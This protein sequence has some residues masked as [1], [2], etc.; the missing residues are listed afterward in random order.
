M[1][2]REKFG[3]LVLLDE[4]EAG[5]LGREYRA[6]R[7]GPAGLDRFV[8][9]L[10]FGPEVSSNAEA[11][12]RL[13]EEAR[14]AARLQSP[15]LVRV[16]G[17]GRVEQSFYVSTE[18][19]EGR[20][21]A[22]TLE[23]CRGDA[24][25]FAAEHALMIASRAAS[26]LEFLHGKKDDAGAA[27]V[28]GLIAPSRLVVAF[29][30]EVKLKGLGLWPALRGTDLLPVEER[31][32]LAPEQLAGGGGE[33][34]SDVYALGLV[35]LEVLTGRAPDGSD[36]LDG[37]GAATITTTAGEAVPLPKPLEELLRRALARE[38]AARFPGVADMRRA[39]DALLFTGDFTP[40]T[41]DLA[42]F[43]HTLFRDD[44]EREAHA[45]E[46]ARRGDYREFLVEEKP[47]APLPATTEVPAPTQAEGARPVAAD[48]PASTPGPGPDASGVRAAAA[49]AREAAARMT[50]G[51]AAAPSP[52]GR[53]GL[54]L[55]LGLLGAVLVGGG[56]GWTYFV[57]LRGPSRSASSEE[58][59]AAQ[60]RVR[61]LETRIAQLE[62]EKAGAGG[63]TADPTAIERAQQEARPRARAEQE[64]KQQEERGRL[65]EER[66]TEVQRLA[67]DATPLPV[68]A[69]SLAPAGATAG[70]PAATPTPAATATPTPVPAPTPTP[71]VPPASVQP[72][73]S[74]Q[75]VATRPAGAEPPAAP[76]VTSPVR[77]GTLVDVNDPTVTP[78]ALV[79][80]PALVYPDLAR[81][82]RVEG[83]VELKA[84]IDE[85]GSVVEEVLVRC[86]RPNYRFESEAERHVRGRRYQPARKDGVAVRVWLPI[87]VN[88]RLAR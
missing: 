15:G 20:S 27:L 39:L 44:M 24:F 2:L 48:R 9:V 58:T 79:R 30:G 17:I 8:T 45:L 67:A 77:R 86:S 54:W 52:G 73:S 10:R 57:R 70:A 72:L 32:Y 37:L 62:H 84:L 19:V 13:M 1:A 23:H 81:Q 26:A 12:R 33:T 75:S 59:S 61:E 4:T 82:A 56:A 69:P 29:D 76:P 38:P 71:A 64:S 63:T 83:V 80:Q 50:L 7:L 87:V 78:P 55:L 31:R 51:G 16:L 66:T 22:A 47:A 14:L 18:L 40:T 85:N 42:F 88:F 53:R 65:A 34:R 21:V 46:E 3:R 68:Q 41:F 43:M 28:H 49:R 35:M 5:A 25:P 36:P 11:T 6:A 60:A 74:G